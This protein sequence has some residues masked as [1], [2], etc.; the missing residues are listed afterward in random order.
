MVCLNTNMEK[1]INDIE[2]LIDTLAKMLKEKKQLDEA[3]EK[4]CSQISPELLY[5]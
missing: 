4:I 3:I 2:A 5:K 1:N